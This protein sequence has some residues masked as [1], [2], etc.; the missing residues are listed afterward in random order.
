MDRL[1]SL[2]WS[3]AFALATVSFV[4]S[5]AA[6][7]LAAPL[8]SITQPT[9]NQMVTG[10]ILIQVA[11]QSDGNQPITRLEIYV[12]GNLG[13]EYVLATPR[14]QGVQSFTWDFSLA[15]ASAHTIAARAI[16]KAGDFGD[17]QITVNV[18]RADTTAGVDRVPPVINIY[19]PAQGAKVAGE[20][21]IRADATDNVGVKCVFFYIDGAFHTL[22][23]NAP[24]YT[25]LWDTARVADGPHVL[26]AKALDDAENPAS[27]AEVTV[28]VE[29]HSMTTA[30][31]GALAPQTT[32]TTAT[33]VTPPIEP[34][35]PTTGAPELQPPQTTVTNTQFGAPPVTGVSGQ[36]EVER[37]PTP[38]QI[39]RYGYMPGISSREGTVRTSSPAATLAGL[40]AIEGTPAAAA[41]SPGGDT[42]SQALAPEGSGEQL[43]ALDVQPRLTVPRRLAAASAVTSVG[44]I[45]ATD[46][47]ATIDTDVAALPGEPRLTM[48]RRSITEMAYMDPAAGDEGGWA[49]LQPAFEVRP[50]D[51]TAPEPRLTSPLRELAATE[52]VATPELL[53]SEPR[54]VLV[55]V[56]ADQ[57]DELI[58]AMLDQ[59]TSTPALLNEQP[60]LDVAAT[61]TEVQV[62]RVAAL[63]AD[64]RRAAIPAYGRMTTPQG[65]PIAPVAMTSFEDIKVLFDNE[66]L[67]LLASPEVRGGI[68]MAGLREIFEHTDGVLYWFPVEKRVRAVNANT[69]IALQI[70]DAKVRVNNQVR[71]LEVAPYIKQ[72]R[73]MVPLQFIADTLDVTVTF[74]PQTGQICLTS[75]KF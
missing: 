26:Q 12:D 13:N 51:V 33:V 43:A 66:A 35:V 28:F 21:E 14:T 57:A 73:T 5:L 6:P 1:S 9:Q 19:Y 38:V 48:P 7:A 47:V 37:A 54:T 2:L 44:T 22:I 45:S 11:F 39:A 42:A 41:T 69:D 52:A 50:G 67:E 72:G 56:P 27:S 63:P 23:A 65:T 32:G 25:D 31:A 16:D 61:D 18:T 71:V 24:P 58:A 8:V 55:R 10:Q 70:G 15:S 40:P 34:A 75:N 3:L 64:A 62:L 29:N 60:G 59:R 30:P 4:T 36:R 53:A 20:I 68:S 17:A 46:Q 49:R 74:N